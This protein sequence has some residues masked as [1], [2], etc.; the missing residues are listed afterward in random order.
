[1]YINIQIQLSYKENE[2]FNDSLTLWDTFLSKH[3]NVPCKS[4][5]WQIHVHTVYNNSNK[6]KNM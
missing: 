6:T 1:M 2:M 4:I 3:I 5:V